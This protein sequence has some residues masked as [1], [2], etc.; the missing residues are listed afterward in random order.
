MTEKST[1]YTIRKVPPQLDRELRRR[2]RQEHKSLNEMALWA[3]ERGLGLSE[4]SE[5]AVR[6]H[7]LDDL[8]GTWVDDPAFDQA[9][10]AMDQ[11]DPELWR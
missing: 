11:V 7:D 5:Q 6:H 10:E 9:I 1:Q 8:A 4:Q 3:L 2:A